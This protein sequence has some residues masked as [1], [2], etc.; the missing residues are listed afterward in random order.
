MPSMLGYQMLKYQHIRPES[1]QTPFIQLQPK[2][3]SSSRRT[4]ISPISS[5]DAAP[6]T[7]EA[8][9]GL[10]GVESGLAMKAGTKWGPAY[11]ETMPWISEGSAWSCVVKSGP[12]SPSSLAS[13]YRYRPSQTSPSCSLGR[14]ETGWCSKHWTLIGQ[15]GKRDFS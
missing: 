13:I 10:S 6:A 8:P 11:R 15:T 14:T 12:P 3:L 5:M 7:V 9:P 2:S 1:N 4:H